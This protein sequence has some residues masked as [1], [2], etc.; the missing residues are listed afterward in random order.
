MVPDKA[1]G[2][3]V[4]QTCRAA[5]HARVPTGGGRSAGR[6]AE[7]APGRRLRSNRSGARLVID[8]RA[9]WGTDWDRNPPLAVNKGQIHILRHTFCSH[10]AMRGVPAKVI[11]ELAG[12]ADLTTT[13][14][15]MHL[16]KGSKEA[17]IAVLDRPL[18]IGLRR[19][20]NRPYLPSR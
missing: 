4:R 11:Q 3:L 16:A 10:L 15:Y 14:R 5:I 17:A 13:M 1:D 8:S 9:F 20:A 7:P 12:H 18:A 6:F 19:N 2:R